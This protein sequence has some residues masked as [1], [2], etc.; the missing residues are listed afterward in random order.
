MLDQLQR[1]H[2]DETRVNI[3]TKIARRRWTERRTLAVRQHRSGTISC[4]VRFLLFRAFFKV[5]SQK[6]I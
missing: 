2:G 6:L 3:K 5:E 1:N 4:Y